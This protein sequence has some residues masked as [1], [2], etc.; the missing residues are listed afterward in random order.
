MFAFERDVAPGIHRVEDANVNWYLVEDEDGLT[1][2]DAGVPGSWV[3]L[4]LGLS[5]LGRDAGEIRALV[6][7][8]AHFDHIGF[9]ERARTELEVPVLVHEND[10]PLARK[11]MQYAHERARS[12]YLLTQP[13]AL[14]YVLGFLRARA[15]WPP[16]VREVQRYQGGTLSVPGSPE[17]VFTPGHTLGHCALHF[18]DRDALIV[19]D[20]LV[21]VDPYTGK[22]GPRL[23]AGAATA[24]SERALDSLEP[25]AATAAGTVLSGH[26]EPWRG[27][28]GDAVGRA[29]RAGV[30]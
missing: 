5:E 21:M 13:R 9:A 20:A 4:R 11:P 10:V 26:G 2:V 12:R 17:V 14:P 7:T 30:Q 27:G 28:I 3:S 8:H 16:A 18:P 1:I 19:G 15:F 25:L 23:V 22:E 24:D 29:R 6:L